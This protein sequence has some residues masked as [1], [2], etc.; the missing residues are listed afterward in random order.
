MCRQRLIYLLSL[1]ISASISH[2]FE[3]KP[4]LLDPL[5]DTPAC[6]QSL[7]Q[8][9]TYSLKDAQLHPYFRLSESFHK[10]STPKWEWKAIKWIWSKREYLHIRIGAA[11]AA[12]RSLRTPSCASAGCSL[13]GMFITQTDRTME[14]K[15]KKRNEKKE[16]R[17]YR[18]KS[19]A[20]WSSTM[21]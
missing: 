15:S 9:W 20:T 13:W 8:Q 19:L 11:V 14:K 18:S 5:N 17:E 21:Q 4:S 6:C 10:L 7:L 3:L 12:K 16:K 2:L 1:S